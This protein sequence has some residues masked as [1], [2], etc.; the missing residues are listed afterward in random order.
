MYVVVIKSQSKSLIEGN[1]CIAHTCIS[2]INLEIEIKIDFLY[3]VYVVIYF[4]LHS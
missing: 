2:I 4:F 1:T 3:A